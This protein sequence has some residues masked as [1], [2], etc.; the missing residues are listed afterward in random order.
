LYTSR[1]TLDTRARAAY[2]GGIRR[3]RSTVLQHGRAFALLVALT[4]PARAAHGWGAAAVPARA[5]APA[6]PAPAP[7]AGT[8]SAVPVPAAPPPPPPAAAAPAAPAPAADVEGPMRPEAAALYTRGL[9]RFSARDYA[10]AIADLQA[11]YAIE[12]R[13]EFLFAAGQ[14][15]RLAGD[16]KGA[17]ALYQRFLATNPP[18]VQANATQIA[19]GRCAQHLAEHPEILVVEPPRQPAPPPP[20]PPPWWR[21][22]LGLGLSGAGLAGIGVGIGF[23]AAS[24]SARS[25]AGAS[26]SYDPYDER[27]ATAE[28]RWAL[29][30]GTLA[31]GTALTA[32]G[33]TRFV[34]VRRQARAAETAPH[35]ITVSIKPGGLQVG[36]TF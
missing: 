10:G 6:A 34:L 33:V 2:P 29:G 11:G 30:V 36:G 7:A 19:L 3:W 20:A 12:P 22:P 17:I 23:I 16:C 35:P 8:T 24:F 14:A 27:W 26:P 1:A 5:P 15:K 4:M 31:L 13:R 25:D 18:A 9:E 32:V 21:D 28:S